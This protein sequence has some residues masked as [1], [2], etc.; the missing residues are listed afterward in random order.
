MTGAGRSEVKEEGPA[1]PVP[2]D[3]SAARCPSFSSLKERA[4][5]RP[6][7]SQA[8]FHLDACGQSSSKKVRLSR[9]LDARRAP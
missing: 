6:Q 3:M 7:G 5:E 1:K 9:D 8:A 2:G 4:S